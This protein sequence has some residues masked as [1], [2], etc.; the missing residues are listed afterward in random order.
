MFTK[1]QSL[2]GPA[3][4]TTWYAR[5]S[6]VGGRVRS[7]SCHARNT[8]EEQE[9]DADVV[10]SD[11]ARRAGKALGATVGIG[12]TCSVRN[13]RRRRT[14]GGGSGVGARRLARR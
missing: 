5:E 3:T 1:R 7:A 9:A 12:P 13:A 4:I 14:V 8:L 2:N 10:H 6:G 11:V